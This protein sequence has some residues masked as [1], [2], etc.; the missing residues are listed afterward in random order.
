MSE[1]VRRGYA[2]AEFP[3]GEWYRGYTDL[4]REDD[5]SLVVYMHE[6]ETSFSKNKREL[7]IPLRAL[8]YLW[9]RKEE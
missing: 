9:W 7:V 4:V 3:D 5:G 8:K 1:L 2:Q 6:A